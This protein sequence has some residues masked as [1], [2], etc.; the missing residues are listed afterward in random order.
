MDAYNQDE[1][2][3]ILAV[4]GQDEFTIFLAQGGK[5]VSR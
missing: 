2:G 1:L 5:V 3:A 4:D